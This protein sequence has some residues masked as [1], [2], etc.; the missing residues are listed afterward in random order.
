[1][2]RTSEGAA[3]G[4]RR[5]QRPAGQRSAR[6][7]DGRDRGRAGPRIGEREQRQQHLLA[8]GRV[9][10]AAA[11]AFQAPE[12]FVLRPRPEEAGA[13]H[14]GLQEALELGIAAAE[15]VERVLENRDRLVEAMEVEELGSEQ[16]GRFCPP[17]GIVDQPVR[18]SQVLSRG[19]AAQQRLGGAELEQQV[20]ALRRDGRLG[21]RPAEIRDC[22]VGSTARAGAPSGF[23]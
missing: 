1:M 14:P 7:G 16:R 15:L 10:A 20:R 11:D 4:F 6:Q 8:E 22:A 13:D 9:A 3:A 19:L 2:R 18:L 12:D 21:E 5:V 23:P 17:F